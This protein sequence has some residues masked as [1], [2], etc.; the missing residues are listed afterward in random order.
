MMSSFARLAVL[1]GAVALGVG[2][3]APARGFV[4]TRTQKGKPFYWPTRG[5]GLELNPRPPEGFTTEEVL[6]ILRRSAAVWSA[7][8]LA[9]TDLALSAR[10]P[11][12]APEEA[13][14]DDRNVVVFRQDWCR[15]PTDPE[16][17]TPLCGSPYGT[18]V[19][20]LTTVFADVHT[21]RIV[22]GDVEINDE[23]FDWAVLEP[24]AAASR[25]PRLHDIENV[26]THELGHFL[27]LDHTCL[28]DGDLT[29]PLPDHRGVPQPRCY[30][31]P[32]QVRE[33]TMFPSSTPGN[34]E[35]RSLADDDV[36]GICSIYPEGQG[37]GG[38][39]AVG[40]SGR[41]GGLEGAGL[42]LLG[43]AALGLVASRRR[44]ARGQRP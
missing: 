22:D 19:L 27:G 25:D 38:G 9:C 30:G 36:L 34:L 20:A 7:P 21:G 23:Y 35:L 8:A 40:R 11:T 28:V 44:R 14:R 43:L 42:P 33:A 24:G 1:T 3:A 10:V 12:S 5:L 13:A 4:R 16:S 15:R 6:S 41:S 2:A 32:A 39:C 26:V 29:P 37:G 17:A 31:A 18:T